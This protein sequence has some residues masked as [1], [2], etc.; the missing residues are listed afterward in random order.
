MCNRLVDQVQMPLRSLCTYLTDNLF[1][2]LQAKEILFI[3]EVLNTYIAEY[4]DQPKDKVEQDCDR[5]FFMTPVSL[6]S[7]LSS[8]WADYYFVG[9]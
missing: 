3:R 9:V 6:L 1:F 4:C 8:C 5:D 2:R 7:V